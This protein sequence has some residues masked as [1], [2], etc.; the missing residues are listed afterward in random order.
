MKVHTPYKLIGYLSKEFLSSLLIVF[1]VF[2]SLALLINFV[3]EMSFF[4][5]KKINNLIVMVSF[6]SLCKTLNTLIELSIFI[7]LFSGILFFVKIQKN[8]EVNTILLSGISKHIPILT[9]AII[10][11]VAGII[12]VT[13]ISPISAYTLNIYEQN[14][15]LYS[16]NDNLIVI[17]NNG[18]WF[19]E[20]L[21]NGLNIIKADTVS[22]NDFTKLKNITIYNLDLNFRFIKRIDSKVAN[23][24][25][26]NWTLENAKIL[27]SNDNSNNTKK[28]I[29]NIPF[30]SSINI[31]ELKNYFSNA[32]TVSFWD[33][34]KN[35]NTLKLRGYSGD[36]LKIKYHKYLSL[37]IYLFG[38]ILLS[39]IFTIG[40][41]KEYNTIIYLFFGL[42]AGFIMYF[43]N[44][45]S[46][47]LGLS[48]KL[49]LIISVWAPIMII[50]ILSTINLISIN[51]K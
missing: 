43:L 49:P 10:S 8:S 50:I 22:N 24:S 48:R 39:T 21:E 14:K 47:A 19:M 37:P 25:N 32:N 26:K 27:F 1:L 15:R 30:N 29:F 4:K 12:I 3:E 44:D 41:N 6:L 20:T 7:F 36:E 23:I 13:S 9:P 5:E 11:V 51:E 46:I 17:N 2:L 16:S 31:D 45:L 38:M 18:L 33:I 42:I 28:N 34:N 40:I 35:I